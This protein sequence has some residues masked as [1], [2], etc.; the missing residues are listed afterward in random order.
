MSD[1]KN[2][3]INHNYI[4]NAISDIRELASEFEEEYKDGEDSVDYDRWKSLEHG[5]LKW[6]PIKSED[7]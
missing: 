1:N 7:N 4:L 2:L 3:E 5:T 6:E